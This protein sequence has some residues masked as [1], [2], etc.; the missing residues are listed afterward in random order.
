[1]RGFESRYLFFLLCG[2]VLPTLRFAIDNSGDCVN[3]IKISAIFFL[4]LSLC[5]LWENKAGLP[6]LRKACSCSSSTKKRFQRIPWFSHS[7]MVI[8][9]CD[10]PCS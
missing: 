5:F 8:F 9:S 6:F 7:T 1:M 4:C 3:G 10:K 2:V